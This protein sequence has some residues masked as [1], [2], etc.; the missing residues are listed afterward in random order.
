MNRQLKAEIIRRFGAQ[1]PFAHALGIREATVSSVIQGKRSLTE[2]EQRKW[3][4][5]LSVDEPEKLF[6]GGDGDGK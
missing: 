2:D 5:L 6:A 4:D 1:Y 3:A